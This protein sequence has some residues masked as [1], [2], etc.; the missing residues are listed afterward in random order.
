MIKVDHALAQSTLEVFR[1]EQ[2]GKFAEFKGCM[3]EEC[4][5]CIKT[6]I[7]NALQA[8]FTSNQIDFRS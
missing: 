2:S 5:E 8:L 4:I 6:A 7:T 3:C 1:R